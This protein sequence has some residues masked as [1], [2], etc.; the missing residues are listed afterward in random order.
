MTNF[1]FSWS[2]L[3]RTLFSVVVLAGVIATAQNAFSAITFVPGD[4]YTSNYFSLTIT[5]YDPAGQVVGTVTVPSSLGGEVR[6]LAFGPD[7]LL[8][9][10]LSRD[11]GGF[12]VLAFNSSGAVQQSYLGTVYVAGNLSYGKIAL[13]RH[14]LYIAG[15]DSLTRYTLGDPSSATVIY[16][17]N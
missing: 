5:Q 11:S 16:I 6:G 9:A 2:L 12:A 4:Y 10:T 3:L 8:Y 14:Y 1:R 13:D 7:G 17:N 15:Q